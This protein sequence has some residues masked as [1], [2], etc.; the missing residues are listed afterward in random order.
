MK[1]QFIADLRDGQAVASTFSGPLERNSHLAA[2]QPFVA[3]ARTGA[4]AP[5]QF[6]EKC[7]M[8]SRASSRNFERDDVV[9]VRARAKLYNDQLELTVEQRIPVAE[10]DYEL[11]RFSSAHEAGCRETLRTA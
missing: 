1:T 3:A 8:A 11:A 7:G 10:K 6:R 5:A 2:N 4:I 9:K